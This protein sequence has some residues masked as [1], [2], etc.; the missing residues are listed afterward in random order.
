MKA[1]LRFYAPKLKDNRYCL[2][3]PGD[4]IDPETIGEH[5]E[6]LIEKGYIQETEKKVVKKKP[7]TKKKTTKPKG[8]K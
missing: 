6:R 7:T 4:D 1:L 8:T 2:Y 3:N 5:L